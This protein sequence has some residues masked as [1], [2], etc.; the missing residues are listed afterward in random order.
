MRTKSPVGNDST[1]RSNSGCEAI[2]FAYVSYR[3]NASGVDSF[4]IGYSAA[5]AAYVNC[6]KRT[7]N[8]S[9]RIVDSGKFAALTSRSRRARRALKSNSIAFSRKPS[10]SALIE[11]LSLS[12]RRRSMA[13]AAGTFTSS[14]SVAAIRSESR[15]SKLSALNGFVKSDDATMKTG[16]ERA[17]GM[18]R[19]CVR[20]SRIIGSAAC[21]S[22]TI[23]STSAALFTRRS[24]SRVFE[25]DS[26]S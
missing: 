19:S 21:R 8:R 12:G 13:N 18:E 17:A 11:S 3:L 4:V 9:R 6:G 20:K 24:T 14:V 10:D 22:S 25:T 5:N 15:R 2:N 26:T 16:V 7:R 23:K 1:A